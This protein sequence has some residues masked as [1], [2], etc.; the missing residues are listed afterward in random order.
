MPV[1]SI[2]R[3]IKP[4]SA[5]IS[6]TRCPF[7]VPP[8]AGLHGMWATV[9]FESVHR[10]TLQ[11]RRAAAYA[12]STPACPAPMTMTSN[13]ILFAYAEPLENVSQYIFARAAAH[14]LVQAFARVL[15]IGEQELFR[16]D[17]LVDGVS[18]REKRTTALL[19]QRDVPRIRDR[20][21]V[22]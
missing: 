20:R 11:P 13:R 3:P 5:S 9:S 10:P 19:Q 21:D 22:P 6:R 4:P 16:N 18:R 7:A 2:A 12:A 14:N 15:E 8:I 17:V 1:A